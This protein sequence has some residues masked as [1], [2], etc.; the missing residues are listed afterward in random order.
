MRWCSQATG[1]EYARAIRYHSRSIYEQR[2]STTHPVAP[3]ST[4]P[5]GLQH[6]TPLRSSL[7]D[8]HCAVMRDAGLASSCLRPQAQSD[9][10]LPPAALD[11]QSSRRP[12]HTAADTRW[13]TT[14]L[15]ERGGGERGPT[16]TAP[17]HDTKPYAEK[18]N[19]YVRQMP[20]TH[21][22]YAHAAVAH[23]NPYQGGI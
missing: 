20:S 1:H 7:G 11:W 22:Y 23:R 2:A 6:P 9:R 21:A 16:A 3:H 19:R 8:H 18:A 10:G 12:R 13:M 15:V 17:Q 14:T 4:P 5:G